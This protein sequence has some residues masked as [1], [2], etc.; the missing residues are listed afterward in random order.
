V[1]LGA[2][3][4][5]KE[6]TGEERGAW[7]MAMALTSLNV[8]SYVDRQLL[9]TLAPLLMADLGLTR[10][11]IGL[12]VG[13]SFVAAYGV[14]TLLLGAA[15]DRVSRPR[16]ITGGLL[17]WSL[18]TALTA[19]A[20]GLADLAALRLAVGLGE[21]ALPATALAMIGDR[22]PK[23]RLGLA[24]GVFY[25][26]IPIGFA[27][28]FGLA[29]WLGP[30]LG[31]RACF[32]VLG[33][34]GMVAGAGAL[35]LRDPPRRVSPARAGIR[36]VATAFGAA[37]TA[38]P[39]L[40]LVMLGG[41]LLAYMSSSSQHAITWLVQE[42]GLPYSRAALLAGAMVALGGLLGN[43]AIGAA[44]DSWGRAGLPLGRPGG[45][46]AMGALALPSTAAFYLLPVASPAFLPCWFV[47][48]AFMLGWFGPVTAEMVSLAPEGLRATV[49]GFG[50]L[51]VNLLG[52]ATGPWI[53]GLIGD[54]SSL[55]R[56]LLASLAVGVAGLAALAAAGALPAPQ[57]PGVDQAPS[58]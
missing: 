25:A 23:A 5:A 1:T 13:A 16:L 19:T 51:V 57:A 54:H 30:W 58:S 38:R 21:A 14:M 52:V 56:G 37:L 53:T 41:A 34:L 48:Q 3:A 17:V 20:R 31:W 24:N 4:A 42:R 6:W 28:S 10:A 49:T 12:L 32:V 27:A 44:A 39:R 22:V 29:G 46:V 7:R 18:A 45:L 8:L 47:S 11:Q 2:L 55:T 50:L 40:R 15:A 9:V 35:A 36:E 33:L 43:V 26:G